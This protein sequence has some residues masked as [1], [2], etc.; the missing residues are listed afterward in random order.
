LQRCTTVTRAPARATGGA[1]V[2]SSEQLFTAA[3]VLHAEEGSGVEELL[4]K[5]EAALPD[6]MDR[7]SSQLRKDQIA[8]L[9][10]LRAADAKEGHVF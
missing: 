3:A 1:L 2:S 4:D 5:A 6:S 10:Q 7:G 9:R 8:R